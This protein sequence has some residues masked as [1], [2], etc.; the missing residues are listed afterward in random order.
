M[1]AQ[2]TARVQLVLSS[3][4]KEVLT[5]NQNKVPNKKLIYPIRI[6]KLITGLIFEGISV[7]VV[8]RSTGI[9]YSTLHPWSLK[10][11]KQNL[12]K[13][14]FRK[15]LVL[16]EL[17]PEVSLVTDLSKTGEILVHLFD[18][19][20]LTVPLELVGSVIQILKEQKYATGH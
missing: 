5:L 4:K 16:P 18:G 11:K 1:K 15:L 7:L 3:I 14:S 19:I 2:V 17:N 8:H 13:K 9:P 20:K 10:A 12:L 6:K